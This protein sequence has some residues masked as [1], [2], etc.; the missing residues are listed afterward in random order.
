MISNR[1]NYF[2][3]LHISFYLYRWLHAVL[4]DV[5]AVR[6]HI[7]DNPLAQVHKLSSL[8][9]KIHGGYSIFIKQF[10]GNII[11]VFH[12][13]K[14]SYERT[15]ELRFS[16]QPSGWHS[17]GEIILALA[18]SNFPPFRSFGLCWTVTLALALIRLLYLL[19]RLICIG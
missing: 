6:M 8:R 1:F 16:K 2:V 4:L 15:R 10:N 7:I 19:W 17:V 14:Q 12:N 5:G 13:P 3:L 11:K 18:V 9:K